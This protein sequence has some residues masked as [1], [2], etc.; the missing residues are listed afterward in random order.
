MKVLY[1]FEVE[2]DDEENDKVTNYLEDNKNICLICWLPSIYATDDVKH[3]KDLAVALNISTRCLCN[4]L[5]HHRCIEQWILQTGSCPICRT[6]VNFIP[7]QT[8]KI[9]KPFAISLL[10]FNLT[11][12]IM[13]VLRYWTAFNVLL[14]I[15]YNCCFLY[16]V[17]KQYF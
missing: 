17:K 3:I 4:P 15:L 8:N 10:V 7:K 5:F 2:D 11:S 16:E 14:F 12:S 1:M 6:K 13:Y 9:I